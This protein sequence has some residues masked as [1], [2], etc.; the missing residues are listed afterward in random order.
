MTEPSPPLDFDE[1]REL[2]AWAAQFYSDRDFVLRALRVGRCHEAWA[3][4]Y[5]QAFYG[6]VYGGGYTT[7]T[8]KLYS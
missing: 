3:T 1:Y 8:G 6:I 2:M 7:L 4:V 5:K